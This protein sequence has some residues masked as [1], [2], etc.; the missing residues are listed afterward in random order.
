M[1][2]I[3]NSIPDNFENEVFEELLS[4]ENIRI[5]RIISKGHISPADGWYDQ[6][7]NEWVVVLQGSGSVLFENDS[8]IVLKKGDYLHIPSHVRH[9]VSWTDPDNPTV[10]LAVFYS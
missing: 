10:W 8:E 5:E 9:K 7:E 6:I 1:K 2:N 3:F 4:A